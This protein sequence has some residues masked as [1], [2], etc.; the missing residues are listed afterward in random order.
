MAGIAGRC[1]TPLRGAVAKQPLRLSEDDLLAVGVELAALDVAG[2][3]VAALNHKVSNHAV[4]EQTIEVTLLGELQEV[5]AVRRW[6]Y[7]L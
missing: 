2:A 4:E 7:R 6:F 1:K 5:I 3:R